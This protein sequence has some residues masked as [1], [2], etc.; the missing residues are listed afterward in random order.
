MT[1]KESI[2]I[3]VFLRKQSSNCTCI[4]GRKHA[5]EHRKPWICTPGV[6]N[7]NSQPQPLSPSALKSFGSREER[8]C[9]QKTQHLPTSWK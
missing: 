7:E 2:N 6:N 3:Q 8:R 4:K 1:N 5:N 9:K